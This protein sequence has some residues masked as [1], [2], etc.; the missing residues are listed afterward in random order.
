MTDISSQLHAGY[1]HPL[2]RDLQTPALRKSMFMYP[3]FITDI[4]DAAMDLPSM[5]GQKRW[6]VNKLEGFIRPLVEK[7]LKSVI[8][9]GIPEVKKDLKVSEALEFS[10]SSRGRA[11]P[12]LGFVMS[13][14]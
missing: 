8:L 12:W 7:G 11:D 10:G 2:T 6:G 4:E 9:F 3:L 14:C 5:P 1:A 13:P